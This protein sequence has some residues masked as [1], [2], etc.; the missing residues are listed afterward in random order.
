M[1]VKRFYALFFSYFAVSIALLFYSYTQVDLSL[2]LTQVSVWQKI[3]QAFQH[4]GFYQRPLS[5]ALY[6][7][8]VV[9]LFVLYMVMLRASASNRMTKKQAWMILG[10]L[11]LILVPSYPAF[12][13]DLFNYMFTAKTVLVYQRNPYAIAPIA[14]GGVD[15]WLSFLHWTHLPSAYTPL[16][17]VLTLPAYL[18]GFRYFLVTL[19][20]MKILVALFYLLCTWMIGKIMEGEDPEKAVYSMILFGLNPLVIIESL[21]SAHNDI[22]MMAVALVAVYLFSGRK[23]TAFFVLSISAALKL[24]TGM[25]LPVFLLG[26]RQRI[27][28]RVAS[29]VA[30]SIGLT[31]V[32]LRREIQPWYFVWILPFVSLL[33]RR[34]WLM[35]IA[36][37]S[38]L[39]LLLRYAPYLYYGHWNDPVPFLKRWGTIVPILAAALY[40]FLKKKSI[41]LGG[42]RR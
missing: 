12:S 18:L 30:M 22:A 2:T 5:T 1:R 21:V 4:I 37:A 31:F 7:A 6:L 42:K 24:M 8:I 34:P 25:L 26:L 38:S 17:I 41:R 16:W 35:T 20:N 11:V 36:L 19:W 23:F 15:P 39:G 28:L 33:P 9:A 29:L 14:F 40:L 27:H 3:Q 10:L 32:L 13:R